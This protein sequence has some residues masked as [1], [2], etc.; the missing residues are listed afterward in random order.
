MKTFLVE[1]ANPETNAKAP[2][3]KIIRGQ[4]IDLN[5]ADMKALLQSVT[6]EEV[7]LPGGGQ[8]ALR[9]ARLMDLGRQNLPL[10]RLAEA[11]FDAVALLAEAS[12]QP[13]K[14]ALYGVWASEIPGESL[15]LSGSAISG[16]K[17]FCSGAG[18]VDRALITIGGPD[19]LLVDL[20]LR[21]NPAIHFDES[22]WKTNALIETHTATARFSEV[23]IA[24][25]QVIGPLGWYLNRLGF[26]RGALGPAACWAGGAE[27]LVDYAA[28]QTRRDPHTI[29]H[30]GAMQA[31]VWA[32]RSYLETAGREIDD[33]AS[34][35]EKACIL[36]LTVRHLVEQSCTDILRRLARAYGPHPLV[37]NIEVSRRYQDLDLYL[38]Q[39]HGERD[40]E[41]LGRTLRES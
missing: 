7:P 39:S 37:S 10:A 5:T 23:S 32:L 3:A 2:G 38:R 27:G 34:T 24:P 16:T 41:M 8:T 19:P 40:L 28:R 30:F 35:V 15:A 1:T 17:R 13:E 11:H 31:A 20:D 26:W 12:R 18:I 25:D 36:A 29:A 14:G 4:T 22:D 6:A 9:H 21:E 33:G